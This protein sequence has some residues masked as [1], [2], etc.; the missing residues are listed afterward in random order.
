MRIQEAIAVC[1]SKKDKVY[2]RP[3]SWKNQ[4]RGV[5]LG[6]H[7]KT[8]SVKQVE[9]INGN[10]AIWGKDWNPTPEE[11]MESWEIV[12]VEEIYEENPR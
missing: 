5:D 3:V 8:E 4:G 12:T 11:L 1:K 7:L 6:Q 10:G 2:A 9:V